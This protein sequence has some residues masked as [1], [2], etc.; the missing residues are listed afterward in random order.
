MIFVKFDANGNT[1]WVKQGNVTN[2]IGGGTS[3]K[4]DN[5]GN[6]YVTGSFSGT[7]TLSTFSI[8]TTNTLDMFLARYTG[9]SAQSV[10][11]ITQ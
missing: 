3:L 10:P 2:T 9:D 5:D 1:V 6:F 8:S 4:I 11:L 7:I